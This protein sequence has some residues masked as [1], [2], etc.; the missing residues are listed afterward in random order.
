MKPMN[1]LETAFL[2]A[3]HVMRPAP[4]VA[5]VPIPA[6]PVHVPDGKREIKVGP[7]RVFPGP[8]DTFMIKGSRN[9]VYDAYE[10]LPQRALWL[11][12]ISQISRE[13]MAQKMPR[14]VQ[15]EKEM[16]YPGD[17]L[18]LTGVSGFFFPFNEIEVLSPST[19]EAVVGNDHS[20]VFIEAIGIDQ[21]SGIYVRDLATGDIAGS[22][23]RR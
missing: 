11:R 3:Q 18:L 12:V 10:L 13:E 6:A 2:A 7:A 5:P 23:A 17:E 21:K 1:M 20:H 19:G 16:Y 14:G 9:R 15:L 4:P 8:Y 22:I